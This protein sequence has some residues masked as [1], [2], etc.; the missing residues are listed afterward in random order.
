MKKY[1]LEDLIRRYPVLDSSKN[2]IVS[3]Y[4]ILEETFS[5]G[6]KLLIAGN[7]GSSADAEHIF[8]CCD[9]QELI[10]Q[11]MSFLSSDS[12]VN[13]EAIESCARNYVLNN[14][15]FDNSE[16]QLLNGIDFK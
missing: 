2:E 10:K 8:I 14:Y 7:G 4:C 13:R 16:K 5:S 12:K 3:S 9:K 15:S 11:C 6:N 1:T